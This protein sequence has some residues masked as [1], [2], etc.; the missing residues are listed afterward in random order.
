MEA[1]RTAPAA[2]SLIRPIEPRLDP[3][4]QLFDCRVESLGQPDQRHG[5]NQPAP[6]IGRDF[7]EQARRHDRQRPGEMQAGVVL[8]LDEPSQ[9]APCISEASEARSDAETI[10]HRKH[11]SSDHIGGF[12]HASTIA[13]RRKTSPAQ[14]KRAPHCCGALFNSVP[15]VPI[16]RAVPAPASSPSLRCS[17]AASPGCPCRGAGPSTKGLP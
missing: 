17:R 8:I 7:Q 9:A 4:A 6:V 5:Q 1:M 16:S 15:K 10:L 11:I 14:R 3:I 12:G 13:R 2:M